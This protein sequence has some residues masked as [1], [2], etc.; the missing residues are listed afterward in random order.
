MN[1]LLRLWTINT[2]FFSLAPA[3]NGCVSGKL[4]HF[5]DKKH[6]KISRINIVGRSLSHRAAAER[7]RGGAGHR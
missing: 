3:A 1:N 4:R 5:V 6:P 2:H 7:D